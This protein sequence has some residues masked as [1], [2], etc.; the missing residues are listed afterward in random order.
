MINYKGILLLILL[1]YTHLPTV[2][3]GYIIMIL[4][5]VFYKYDMDKAQR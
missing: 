1:P 3:H 4:V 5:S 2:R